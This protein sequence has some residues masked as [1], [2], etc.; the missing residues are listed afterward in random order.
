[1]IRVL[2]LLFVSFF[3]LPSLRAQEQGFDETSF[4]I[5][6]KR[7]EKQVLNHANKRKEYTSYNEAINYYSSILATD[8]ANVV[9]NYGVARAFY[10][11]FEQLKSIFFFQ[12]ALRHST[13]TINELYFFLANAYHLSAN[14]T[15][16]QQYFNAYLSLLEKG[17]SFFSKEE[18]IEVKKSIT[19]QLEMCE[20]GKK[21]AVSANGKCPLLKVGEKIGVSYIGN[22]INSRY[23]DYG[24]ILS[25]NDSILFYTTKRI[26]EGDVYFS[27]Y[28]NSSW[29]A[30]EKL[31]W[32]INTNSYEAVIN[33]SSDGKRLYFYRSGIEEGMVYYS[34]YQNNHWNIP[35]PLLNKFEV[36]GVFK[37]TRIYSFAINPSKSE[38]FIISD[39]KGG[40]GGKDMYVSQKMADSTWGPLENMGNLI[41][42]QYDEVALSLSEDGNT[43]YFS[44]NGSKSIGGFDVFFTSRTNGQWSAPKSLGVPINTP[45]DDLFFSFLHNSRRA[46]YSSSANAAKSTRDLNMYYVDFCDDVKE[47]T[48]RGITQGF[49][50]GT[51]KVVD[52]ITQKEINRTT[53][54]DGQY[55]IDLSVGKQYNFMF[56]TAGIKPVYVS[57][58]V[59]IPVECKKYDIYQEITFNKPGDTLKFKT[60]L[61]DIEYQKNN[62]DI[63]TYVAL[64]AKMDKTTLKNYREYSV[65]TQ[66]PE[67]AKPTITTVVYDTLSGKQLAKV[68][69]DNMPFDAEKGKI[70]EVYEKEVGKV[71]SSPSSKAVTTFS[72]SN[73]LFDFDKSKIKNIHRAELDKAIEFLN[74]VKPDSSIEVAGYSDSRGNSKYNL[75]LSK[76]RARA[77]ANYL[78]SKKI[79]KNRITIVG[80]GE[81]NPI[82]PNKNADGTDNPEG[83]A[84]NRRT[85]IVIK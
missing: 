35:S 33:I 9:A 54:K 47:N 15:K 49:S 20:N 48:I 60:A 29:S 22:L 69:F 21:I 80:Y 66:V 74:Q 38:L 46:C 68:A 67:T 6:S 18:V 16:A 65:L 75:S 4:A 12:R 84:K 14:Y 31:G 7:I 52:V 81:N 41:N 37:D 56:E 51:V 23:D 77:V 55:A 83:R 1:M 2:F 62:P 24:A 53:I 11:N 34:D 5:I 70:K 61:L 79:N 45:G 10:S 3:C 28:Q 44:S 32:P 42:S 71:S 64:L 19:H 36:N 59:P 13:D 73:V 26:D 63:S 25:P 78:I 17:T 82:A 40:L 72:F 76:L 39:R 57:V 58:I 43:I 27:R 8:S 30:G 85:E 50:T